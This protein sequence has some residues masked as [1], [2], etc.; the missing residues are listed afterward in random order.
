MV[1]RSFHET[2]KLP[3]IVSTFIHHFLLGKWNEVNGNMFE[4]RKKKINQILKK[5]LNFLLI[6]L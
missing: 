2:I 4:E 5:S 1:K 6:S 3:I